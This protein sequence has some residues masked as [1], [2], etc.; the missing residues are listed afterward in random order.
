MQMFEKYWFALLTLESSGES[1]YPL[2]TSSDSRITTQVFHIKKLF[3]KIL[4]VSYIGF[5]KR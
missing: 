5:L 2:V 3:L 4:M 1:L